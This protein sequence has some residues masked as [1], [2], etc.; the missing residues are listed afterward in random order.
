MTDSDATVIDMSARRAVAHEVRAA[1]LVACLRCATTCSACA[2]ACLDGLPNSG[3]AAGVRLALD[4]ADI[5]GATAT[6]LSRHGTDRSA[7]VITL[8]EACAEAC[9]ACAKECE[10]T[11]G[12]TSSTACAPWLLVAARGPV[13]RCSREA[14]KEQYRMILDTG[15]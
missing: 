7:P 1:C 13:A 10:R 8:I 12:R 4:C 5:C 6:V 9:A 15:I 14:T 11:P 2:A 3:S